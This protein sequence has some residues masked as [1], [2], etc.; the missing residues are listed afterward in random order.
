MI[1]NVNV[2]AVIISTVISMIVGMA[3]Y[4]NALFGKKWRTLMG[5]SD[6]EAAEGSK[7]MAKPM[8]VNAVASLIMF[9]ILG[10]LLFLTGTMSTS[11]S[12]ALAVLV[13][14][15]FIACTMIGMVLWERKSCTLYFIVVGYHLVNLVLAGLVFG[16][17]NN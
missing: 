14:L 4:S 12:V 9:F 16:W 11:G 1:S 7:K 5:V 8:A 15:G 17:F 6:A 10:R 13:W 2:W 3:W